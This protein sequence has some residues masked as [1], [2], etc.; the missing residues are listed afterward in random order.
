MSCGARNNQPKYPVTA[1]KLSV[2]IR[3]PKVLSFIGW[4]NLELEA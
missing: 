3:M 4:F 1:N 2:K